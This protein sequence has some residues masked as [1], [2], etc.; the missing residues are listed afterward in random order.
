MTQAVQNVDYKPPVLGNSEDNPLYIGDANATVEGSRTVTQ[1]ADM[2]SR[3]LLE[4]ILIELRKLNLRQ[5]EAFEEI[6]TDE[7]LL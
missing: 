4:G 7:D 6:V 5:E 2:T 3:E 1:V